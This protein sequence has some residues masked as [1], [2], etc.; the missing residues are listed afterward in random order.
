M[1]L[2]KIITLVLTVAL[3]ACTFVLPANAASASLTAS[4]ITNG[5]ATF[6]LTLSDPA[7]VGAA[8]ANFTAT[9]GTITGATCNQAGQCAMNGG[10]LNV[11]LN[12]AASSVS[13]T[14]TVQASGDSV[15]LS[16]SGLGVYNDNADPLSVSA[17]SGSATA[18]APV[19]TTTAAPTTTTRSTAADLKSLSVD[20]YKLSPA[21]RA[22]KTSYSIEVPK[23]FSGDLK[24]NAVPLDSAA[25][26]TVTGAEGYKAGQKSTIRIAV[27]G[28]DGTT[29][30][31]TITV[32][33]PAETTT[34][35]TEALK[36]DTLTI[37]AD[38]A[39]DF[40]PDV[41]EY[42]V[43]VPAGTKSLNVEA[44][45]GDIEG[46]TVRVEGA[47]DLAA[48]NNIVKVIVTD[49]NGTET[50]YTITVQEETPLATT[51]VEKEKKGVAVWLVIM[52]VL[53]A[54]ILGLVIGFFIG[55]KKAENDYYDDDDDDDDDNA[56]FGG[57]A[58][59]E[60]TPVSPY[61]GGMNFNPPSVGSSA[62]INDYALPYEAAAPIND[63]AA[64]A[65]PETPATPAPTP[66]ASASFIQSA[67]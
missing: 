11:A 18:K 48:S 36:L 17:T 30:N 37:G 60:P 57:S 16:Y 39:L 55:K 67:D 3:L 14:I 6:T 59:P 20:G 15:T 7:G 50:V 56:F 49:A 31:Y 47:D 27:K 63:V 40:N 35:K 22:T 58:D 19:V 52:L 62:P 2:K 33:P 38:Y 41:L 66:I 1:K 61:S 28:T 53:F 32:A 45:I 25:T 24:V 43:K 21:F 5:T 4:N 26:V 8:E 42:I 64:P 10:L 9:G 34:V 29:R 23:D 44:L 13:V 54:F 12:N 65:A 51:P 46:A